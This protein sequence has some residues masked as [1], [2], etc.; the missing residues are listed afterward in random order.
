MSAHPL[1]YLEAIQDEII[2]VWAQELHDSN[3]LYTT[4]PIAE[5]RQTTRQCME[6]YFAAIKEE[7]FEPLNKFIGV[8]VSM[9]GAM[10]FPEHEVVDAFRGFRRIASDHLLQGL[11]LGEVEVDP[12]SDVLDAICQVVDYSI[13]RFSEVYYT[14]RTERP[15]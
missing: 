6:A 13:L 15:H 12:V 8:I 14:A 3:S 2:E 5:L 7:D 9:R 4:R 11:V 10:S 1:E